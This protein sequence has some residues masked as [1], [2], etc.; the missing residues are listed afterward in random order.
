[1]KVTDQ[2]PVRAG[3]PLVDRL[4]AYLNG[5]SA[6]GW[7]WIADVNA[8]QTIITSLKPFLDNNYHIVRNV[9]LEGIDRPVPLVLVGSSGVYVLLASGVKGLFRARNEIWMEMNRKI[10]KYAPVR[11]NLISRAQLMTR[12]VESFLIQNQCPHPP[13]QTAMLFADAGAHVDSVRS[14]V[15]IVLKDGME[16]FASSVV[17]GDVVLSKRDEVQEIVDFLTGKLPL[18]VETFSEPAQPAARKPDPADKLEKAARK[19]GWG[20][21]QWILMGLMFFVEA[22]I[23]IFIFVFILVAFT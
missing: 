11:K 17:Q 15:R 1:M 23:L 3:L 19:M 14:A 16:H 2:S 21:K 7:D 8:E 13:V 22:I 20:K 4:K 9:S 5:I 10:R 12:V 18:P 6:Y